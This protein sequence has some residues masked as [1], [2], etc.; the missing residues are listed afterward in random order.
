ML[1]EVCATGDG[2]Y[3]FRTNAKPGRKRFG[4]GQNH[5]P[6]PSR[7]RA[8]SP[9]HRG[10]TCFCNRRRDDRQNDRVKARSPSR[11]PSATSRRHVGLSSTRT[12]SWAGMRLLPA[13][14]Q[15]AGVPHW[16]AQRLLTQRRGDTAVA[17]ALGASAQGVPQCAL[18]LPGPQD[19]DRVD[20][21]CS[22]GSSASSRGHGPFGCPGRQCHCAG[23]PVLV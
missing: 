11:V 21:P 14:R 6:R 2:L 3:G 12:S 1:A 5:K 22:P 4:S 19:P 15:V 9:H 17:P 20:G 8:R 7:R 18:R 23:R 13:R 16:H 10:M